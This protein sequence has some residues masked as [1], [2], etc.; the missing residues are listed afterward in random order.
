MDFSQIAEYLKHPLVLIGFAAFLFVGLIPSLFKGEILKIFPP[1]IAATLVKRGLNYSLAIAMVCIA[2]ASVQVFFLGPDKKGNGSD[3]GPADTLKVNPHFD[4]D[5]TKHDSHDDSLRPPPKLRY[6]L[7]TLNIPRD[8]EDSE[9]SVDDKRAVIYQRDIDKIVVKMKQTENSQRIVV[10]TKISECF[11]DL[12][13]D[14][15]K[16]V[17]LTC[18]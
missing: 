7:I 4:N 15:N 2:I 10:K 16:T 6:Y 11:T 8:M 14:A 3:S 13:V 9:V 12:V 1:E 5:T 17:N 18:R